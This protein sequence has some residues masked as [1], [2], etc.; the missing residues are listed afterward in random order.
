[1]PADAILIARPRSDDRRIAVDRKPVPVR[2]V[3]ANDVPATAT[4]RAR[5]TPGVD[6]QPHVYAGTLVDAGQ[7]TAR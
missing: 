1:M 4:G 6:D 2:K 3:V 5:A 7:G